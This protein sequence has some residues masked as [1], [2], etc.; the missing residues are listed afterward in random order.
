MKR[1]FCTIAML[2]MAT[3]AIAQVAI[4]GSGSNAS[5]GS[6]SGALAAGNIVEAPVIPVKTEADIK[7]VPS[8]GGMGGWAY[9]A[10]SGPCLGPSETRQGGAQAVWMGA[11]GGLQYGQGQSNLDWGC[12]ILREMSAADSLCKAKVQKACSDLDKLYEMLPGISAVRAGNMPDYA[13]A[14]TVA[15]PEPAKRADA[16]PTV[17]SI[18]QPRNCVA[19]Q[20]IAAR[21]GSPVCK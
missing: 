4:S 21:T 8:L 20:Y 10:P 3:P 15:K 16:G 18:Q 19:D 2:V 9:A 17:A 7:N 1:I 5:A 6:L 13:K 14:Q 11:G 12:V